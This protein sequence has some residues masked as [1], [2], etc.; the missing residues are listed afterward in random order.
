MRGPRRSPAQ[1]LACYDAVFRRVRPDPLS[2]P[3]TAADGA[4]RL[5]PQRTLPTETWRT[6][7]NRVTTAPAS[8]VNRVRHAATG[9]RAVHLLGTGP[10]RQA[11]G[12]CGAH[13]H[14][15]YLLP[16]H[17][18]SHINRQPF[19]PTRG[20]A[21][22]KPNY[23]AVEAKMQISLRVKVAEDLLLPRADPVGHLHPT[24]DVAGAEPGR[25]GPVF[26][27][28]ITSRAEVRGASARWPE[29]AARRLVVAHAG[30]GLCPP[31]QWQSEPLSRSWNRLY[32]GT[33]F[34]KGELAVQMRFN[35][36]PRARV[37]RTTTRT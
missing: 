34:E 17:L 29:R 31:V 2:A 20:A 21:P 26:A 15:N 22:L 7:T 19:S 12:L 10:Q 11:Q 5:D 13:L 24:L 8:C 25:L 4:R 33:A 1:R 16:L 23:K 30:G 37:R 28:P 18:T 3:A 32:A 35:R 14:P 27:T 36:R 9:Q 6:N